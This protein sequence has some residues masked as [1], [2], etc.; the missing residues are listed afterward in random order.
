MALTA[1]EKQRVLDM[2]DDMDRS[3]LSRI[4]SSIFSFAEW[5]WNLDWPK[6]AWDTAKFIAKAIFSHYIG[7]FSSKYIGDF[8]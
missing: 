2:L 7:N 3:T 4:S 8:F 6:I 1:S 5:L